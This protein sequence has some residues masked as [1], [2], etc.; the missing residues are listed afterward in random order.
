MTTFE[1]THR[2]LVRWAVERDRLLTAR[3]DKKIR[4][5]TDQQLMRKLAG[6]VAQMEKRLMDRGLELA[7]EEL[8]AAR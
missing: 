2:L 3:Q 1:P 6:N 5:T 7:R 4:P 8:K